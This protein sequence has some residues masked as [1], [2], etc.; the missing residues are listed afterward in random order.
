[1]AGRMCGWGRVKCYNDFMLAFSL[2][3]TLTLAV[4]CLLLTGIAL[5]LGGAIRTDQIAID[6]PSENGRDLFLLDAGRGQFARLTNAGGRSAVW[7]ADGAQLAYIGPVGDGREGVFVM[8]PGGQPALITPVTVLGEPRALDWSPDGSSLVLTDRSDGVQSVYLLNLVDGTRRRLTEARG[9]AFAPSWSAQG[10]IAFSWSPVANAEIYTIP[11]SQFTL[12]DSHSTVPRPQRIT[13]NMYTD[14]AADWSPDGQWIVFMSDRAGSSDLYRM[15]PDGSELQ[16][17][18]L[19]PAYEG[20]PSWS[21]DGQQI[22]LISNASGERRLSVM[23]LDGA[24][25][26]L[27]GFPGGVPARPAWRPVS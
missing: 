9:S 2:R 5:A 26:P 18:S 23:S 4:V 10:L 14:T 17:I 8:R 12:I 7:S 3:L 20:D 15:R 24:I 25:Q 22:A 13:E 21:P 16:A 27:T 19:S 1:M 6:A 11:A